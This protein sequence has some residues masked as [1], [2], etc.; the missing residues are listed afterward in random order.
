[1]KNG[2]AAKLITLL[3]LNGDNLSN[4]VLTDMLDR[5]KKAL[6]IDP[7]KKPDGPP[8]M[9]PDWDDKIIIGK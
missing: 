4:D 7:I 9:F 2:T 5:V 8:S 1:M 6:D 3:R